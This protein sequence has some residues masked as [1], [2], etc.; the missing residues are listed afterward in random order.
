MSPRVALGVVAITGALLQALL[1][2][3]QWVYGD[4]YALLL[5]ALDLLETG[6]WP[7]FAKTMSGN[8]RI[9]GALLPLLIAGPLEVWPDYR[10]PALLSGLTHVAAAVLL[11][12]CVGRALG[13]RFAAAYLAIYWLSPWRLYHAGFLWEPAYV[14]LPAA[15]HLFCAYRLRERPHVGWS[16]LLG[17]LLA[18]TAQLHASFLVLVVLTAMLVAR[19]LVR[20]DWRGAA[21]GVGAGCLTLVPTLQAFVAGTLPPLA[22][23]PTVEYPR[24][25]LGVLNGLRGAGRFLR[26]A[27]LDI[28]RRL[29]EVVWFDAPAGE[30]GATLGTTLGSGL[31]T[32][33]WAAGLVTLPLVLY[34][35]WRWFARDP[36]FDPSDNP[37]R[38]VAA[39]WFRAYALWCLAALCGAAALSPVVL[40]GWH[41]VIAFHAACL[42][43]AAWLSDSFR[44][45]DLP[46]RAA[47]VTFVAV[48]V[49]AVLLLAFGHEMYRPRAGEEIRQQDFPDAVRPLMPDPREGHA[50]RV[51][52][53][54]SS[55]DAELL[56]R[57]LLG[58]EDTEQASQRI[59]EPIDDALLQGDDRVVG[60]RDLL[61]ADLRAA[62]GDVAVTDAEGVRQ[63]VGPILGVKRIH[64]ERRGVDEEPRADE[65]MVQPVVAQDVADVLAEEALDALPELLHALGVGLRHPPGAVVGVGRARPERLDPFLDVVVPRNVGNQIAD[66]RERLHRLDRHRLV[67]IEAAEARHAHQ[68]RIA[69]HLG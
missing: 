27:S 60:D 64:L 53:V 2:S 63:I 59:V 65:L 69:V 56:R 12:V 5:P 49:T 34:A 26:L 52:R 51:R 30:A 19:K 4:Q 7:A 68:L 48:E 46:W 54:G 67:Q 8:G 50:R 13:A 25:L 37:R 24:L 18:A 22:P 29:R 61:R 3:R 57:K 43:V 28:G 35:G 1:W 40:Q 47:A 45:R 66:R 10:A 23:T 55:A 44:R 36:S 14:F 32:L 31:V 33:V 9:P 58:A 20:I 62:L 41:V 11:A 38:A 21:L 17:L 16:M 15:L 42:P 6:E 39:D